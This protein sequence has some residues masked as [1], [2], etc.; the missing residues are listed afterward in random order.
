MRE[1][2]IMWPSDINPDLHLT[3]DD[4]IYKHLT[5]KDREKLF[6]LHFRNKKKLRE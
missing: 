1:N 6:P 2:D 5:Q 3:R 4:D